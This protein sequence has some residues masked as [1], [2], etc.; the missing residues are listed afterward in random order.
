MSIVLSVIL[1]VQLYSRVYSK[2]G[3]FLG[4]WLSWDLAECY[5]QVIQVHLGWS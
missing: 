4:G 3:N 2:K 1:G 5:R